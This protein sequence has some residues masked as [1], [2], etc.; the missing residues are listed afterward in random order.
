M[1]DEVKL[2]KEKQRGAQA[3]QLLRN[4][5]LT[6]AFKTLEQDYIKAWAGTEPSDVQARENF[7]RATQILGDIRRHLLKVAQHGKLAQK[8]L[9]DLANQFRPR[10]A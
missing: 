4:E 2:N 3:E 8:Q 7:W 10:A 1:I 9:N 5:M 6:E